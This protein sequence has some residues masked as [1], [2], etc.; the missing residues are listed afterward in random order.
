MRDHDSATLRKSLR[1]ESTTTM[2]AVIR[3]VLEHS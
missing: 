3:R 1:T 2:D